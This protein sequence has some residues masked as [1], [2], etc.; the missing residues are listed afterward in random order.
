VQ[1]LMDGPY[2]SGDFHRVYFGRILNARA[3]GDAADRLG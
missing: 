1:E 2:A 3:A